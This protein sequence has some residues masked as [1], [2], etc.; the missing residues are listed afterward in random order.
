MAAPPDW[1][2]LRIFLAALDLGSITR[3][4]DRCGIATSAAAK[5]LQLLEADSRVPLLE[6]DARGVRPTAAGEVLAR[7]ARALLDFAG[8]LQDDLQ[9]L[10][11]GGLGSVRLHATASALAGHDLAEVLASFATEKPGVRVELQESTSLPILRDLL[12][13]RAD[14]GIVTS[15]GQVPVGLEAR[16][17]REDR[18]LMVVPAA[19]P[20]AARAAVG[21]AEVLEQ[22]LVGALES[23]A[24]ALLLE[25]AAQQLGR[26][27]RYRFRVAGT[28]AIRRL[29]A[30]GHGVTVMPDGV[31]RPYEA[32]L[33]LRGIPLTEPWARRQLRLV[34]RAAELLPASAR[35]L[36][37]HLLRSKPAAPAVASAERGR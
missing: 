12:E 31:A 7:H 20:F 21:F 5:R 23:S 11:A 10:A 18:L 6:R 22:P 13:G 25:E 17:W 8:R 4:A 24:L 1:V 34:A 29:V 27:P 37:D 30:A 9:A 2:T 19:H 26:R 33:G 28:D 36:H 16:P 35:L 32:A 3:A 14:L 15:A